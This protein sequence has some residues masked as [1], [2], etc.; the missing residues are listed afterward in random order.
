MDDN[1]PTQPYAPFSFNPFAKPGDPPPTDNPPLSNPFMWP[2]E[3]TRS[4]PEALQ[5]AYHLA[6]G[7]WREYLPHGLSQVA[8]DALWPDWLF[9]MAVHAATA[10][11][12]PLLPDVHVTAVATSLALAAYY[13]TCRELAEYEPD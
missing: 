4:M 13:D 10:P 5:A 1:Q 2:P 8:Y 3:P 11:L 9:E 6:R 7:E 12:T